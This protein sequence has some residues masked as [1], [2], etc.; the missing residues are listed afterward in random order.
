MS[1]FKS[2][3]IRFASISML[4]LSACLAECRH[5]AANEA[6][7]NSPLYKDTLEYICI[8]K[9]EEFAFTYNRRNFKTEI[10]RSKSGKRVIMETPLKWSYDAEWDGIYT[11]ESSFTRS[12]IDFLF[13]NYKKAIDFV[14]LEETYPPFIGFEFNF[15]DTHFYMQHYV[16]PDAEVG[17]T[18]GFPCASVSLPFLP[19]G[20]SFENY[21]NNN[22]NEPSPGNKLRFM[23]L[24][25]CNDLIE[26]YGASSGLVRTFKCSGGFMRITSPMGVRVCEF[27]SNAVAGFVIDVD[28]VR[29]KDDYNEGVR[30]TRFQVKEGNCRYIN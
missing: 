30:K 11:Q 29:N 17:H 1:K 21:L 22:F 25:Q 8:Y 14:E 27:N 16:S 18:S 28:V 3:T 24:N 6:R 10:A 12:T 4:A 2:K 19:T 23:N 20:K 5:A 13:L 15:K 9:D 7:H 26:G